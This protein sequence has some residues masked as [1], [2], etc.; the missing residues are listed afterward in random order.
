MGAKKSKA[1]D[2]DWQISPSHSYNSD[3]N[4][5]IFGSN[6][7]GAEY[8]TD[9]NINTKKYIVAFFISYILLILLFYK[10]LFI[11]KL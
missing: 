8:F 10:Y 9:M 1:A 6:K 2:T 3:H 7:N 4:T 11:L 5:S